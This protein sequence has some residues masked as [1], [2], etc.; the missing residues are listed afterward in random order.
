[1]PEKSEIDQKVPKLTGDMTPKTGFERLT[2][3]SSSNS[4]SGPDSPIAS[5]P[6]SPS[7]WSP[8]YR[9]L[10]DRIYRRQTSG[11]KFFSLEF[12]PPRTAAGAVN[13]ISRFVSIFF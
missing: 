6:T 2:F 3:G 1:M 8:T 5:R 9:R 7:L 4:S 13:L 12:F 11:D 10:I